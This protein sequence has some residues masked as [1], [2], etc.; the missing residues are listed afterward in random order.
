MARAAHT[1]PSPVF[2]G[3]PAYR[4]NVTYVPIQFFTVVLPNCSRGTIRVVGHVLRKILGWVDES[5]RPTQ[6]QVQ[7]TYRELIEK[8]GVSRPAIGQALEEALRHRFLRCVRAPLSDREGQPGCSGVYELCWNREGPYTN[9]LADFQGFHYAAAAVLEEGEGPAVVRRPGA[10]RKNIPNAFFDILLPHERLSVIRVVGAIL[11]YSIKWG[12]GGERR[13]P[14]ELSITELSQLTRMSRHHAYEAVL[15][16]MRRGYIEAVDAGCFDPAAG[17]KSRVATYAIRWLKGEAA[18]TPSRN[19]VMPTGTVLC[20]SVDG[21]RDTGERLKMVNGRR[22]RKVNG[23]RS[24]KVNGKRSKKVNGR[25]LKMVNGSNIKT[26]SKTDLTTAAGESTPGT[27]EAVGLEPAAA[28][29]DLLVKQ[30]F[31][32]AAARQL[33]HRVPLDVIQRQID[34]MHGRSA[35]RNRLGLLRRAIEQ[36]WPQPEGAGP[37][38]AVSSAEQ[39]QARLFAA[40]YYGAYHGLDGPA[41]TEPFPKDLQAADQFVAR[42]LELK[43][44]EARVPEWGRQFGRLMRDKHQGDPKAKPNLSFALTLF[45]AQFLAQWQREA[46]ARRRKAL[47]TAREQHQGAFYARYEDYLRQR[48]IALQKADAALYAAF[49]EHRSDTRHR[50][51]GGLFLASADTLAKF[52]SERSR[53]HGFAEFFHR[54]A[55]QPVLDFWEWDARLNPRRFGSGTPSRPAGSEEAH[56]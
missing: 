51:N 26:E 54:H 8:A 36:D 32:K 50:M 45:G 28:A 12:P 4:A 23:K 49:L 20:G 35:T 22:L 2:Q 37:A 30:G 46:A 52:D 5:G 34:W 42:L 38:S 44:E 43:G 19:S 25:R 7:F 14:V 21:A 47:G 40:H 13:A 1:T 16:A 17:R 41:Q 27:S 10:A 11:F 55:Q 56:P 31:D 15:E 53:L 48:E 18:A 6:E 33:A 9:K 3:F 24:K 39:A 29:A